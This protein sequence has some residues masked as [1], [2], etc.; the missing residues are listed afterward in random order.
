VNNFLK[1]IALLV[2]LPARLRGMVFGHNSYIGP[3]YDWIF[4]QLK[5]VVL[6]KDVVIGRDAWIQTVTN[7]QIEIGDGTHIGRNCTISSSS[8]IAIGK[9]CLFSYNVSVIDHDHRFFRNTSPVNTGVSEGT[10]IDI[11]D[12]VFI[13]AHSFILKGVKLGK[14]CVVGANSVVTK[15]FPDYSV[16][17]GNPAKLVKTLS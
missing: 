10:P 14:N 13:G 4:A 17:A 11:G 6:G 3:G 15:S 8:K 1:T 9:G 16:I 7:G 12:C 5:G 2:S